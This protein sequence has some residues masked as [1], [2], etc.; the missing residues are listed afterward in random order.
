MMELICYRTKFAKKDGRKNPGSFG[1]Q[2]KY[3]KIVLKLNL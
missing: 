2:S 1:N 3:L